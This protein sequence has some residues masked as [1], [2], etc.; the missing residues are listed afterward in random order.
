MW[1]RTASAKARVL[2]EL[3][4]DK[5]R[6]FKDLPRRLRQAMAAID[7]VLVLDHRGK[8]LAVVAIVTVDSGRD[9]GARKAAATA[10]AKLG[11]GVKISADGEVIGFSGDVTPESVKQVFKFG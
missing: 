4:S 5:Q 7:G 1:I 10:V 8:V 2:T 9:A 11:F 6:Q 3:L